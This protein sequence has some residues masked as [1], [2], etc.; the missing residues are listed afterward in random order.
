[1]AFKPQMD[2]SAWPTLKARL[3]EVFK[4]KTRDEWC[5]IME[6]TDVCFAPVLTMAEAPEHP[7][8]AAR[9]T[10]VDVGG[11]VQPAPAPRFSRTPGAIAGPPVAPGSH[12]DEALADWGF[13]PEEIAK[14]RS[15]GAIA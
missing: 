7:H 2:R 13:S 1:E 12:T 4:T 15:A 9:G 8:N 3:A 5:R 10:F 11:V 14:A 6:G